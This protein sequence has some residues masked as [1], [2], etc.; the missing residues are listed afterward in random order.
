[1]MRMMIGGNGG[2][3]YMVACVCVAGGSERFYSI[4]GVKWE[5]GRA[6]LAD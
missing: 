5:R 2:G 1:M 6:N 3:A 4:W